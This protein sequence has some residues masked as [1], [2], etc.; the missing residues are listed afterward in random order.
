[1]A[2]TWVHVLPIFSSLFNILLPCMEFSSN[3]NTEQRRE[4]D[5]EREKG[6][7]S[8]LC[9]DCS[10]IEA[11]SSPS[12]A[13][14]PLQKLWFFFAIK[15]PLIFFSIQEEEEQAMSV[16]MKWDLK[17]LSFSGSELVLYKNCH[18]S[19]RFWFPWSINSTKAINFVICF[20]Y[21][22]SGFGSVLCLFLH[23]LGILVI[24]VL[25]FWRVKR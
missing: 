16:L 13:T 14:Q 3:Y 8:W 6:K 24:E 25:H 11:R 12:L 15:H 7:E 10:F 17:D 1:M 21:F 22:W 9:F 5:R 19:Q 18:I 4:R 20:F 2:L 23:Q